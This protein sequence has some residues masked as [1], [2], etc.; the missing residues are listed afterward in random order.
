MQ[1]KYIADGRGFD[2][3]RT[4]RPAKSDENFIGFF[5]FQDPLNA[6]IHKRKGK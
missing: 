4:A 3:V 6:Y 2:P 1:Y 5:I